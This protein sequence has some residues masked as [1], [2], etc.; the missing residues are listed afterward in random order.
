MSLKPNTVWCVNLMTLTQGSEAVASDRAARIE[1][2][3]NPPA[4]LRCGFWCRDSAE[5][6]EGQ[7]NEG[8][9]AHI[10]TCVESSWEARGTV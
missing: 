2:H 1:Q 3:D 6:T 4:C 5:K 10:I 9:E 8:S 7:K